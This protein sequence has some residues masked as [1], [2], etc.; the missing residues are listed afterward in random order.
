MY[1]KKESFTSACFQ[2]QVPLSEPSRM[3][4]PSRPI[5]T[6]VRNWT[7][8]PHPSKTISKGNFCIIEP[9]SSEKHVEDLFE[10]FKGVHEEIWTY[11]SIGPFFK[12][13]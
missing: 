8:R 13:H 2:I 1:V 7:S 9:L 12:Q 11:I 4:N 5:G 3:I 6:V 10:S